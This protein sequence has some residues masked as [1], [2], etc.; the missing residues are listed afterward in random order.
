MTPALTE[1]DVRQIRSQLSTAN[2]D[3]DAA[4]LTLWVTAVAQER[5]RDRR[6]TGTQPDILFPYLGDTI[7]AHGVENVL[8]A[9]ETWTRRSGKPPV[10]SGGPSKK[11]H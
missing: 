9:A 3:M 8:Y 6:R 4:S 2:P 1:G 5:I 7:L 11:R 10:V